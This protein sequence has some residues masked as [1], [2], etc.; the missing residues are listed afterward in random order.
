MR[1]WAGRSAGL[2]AG[3]VYTYA[4][5][6]LLNLYVRADL[7]ESMAFVWLPL[8]LSAARATVIGGGVGQCSQW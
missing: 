3:L 7:A 6:H 8:C 5:Y 4:P 2:I 1:S